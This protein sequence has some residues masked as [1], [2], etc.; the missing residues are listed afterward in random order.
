MT[1][2]LFLIALL[3][4]VFPHLGCAAALGAGP[5]SRPA[6]T[7]PHVARMTDAVPIDKLRTEHTDVDLRT[8]ITYSKDDV[9]YFGQAESYDNN[10]DVSATAP[11]V[12]SRIKGHW[13]A[14]SLSDDRLPD[15]EFLFIAAGPKKD[16]LWGV[17]D[18]QIGDPSSVL[19]LAHS[20]DSGQTWQLTT[21]NKPNAAGV[22][23]S[24]AMD[25]SGHGRVSV[26]LTKRES[27]NRPGYYH[28]RTTDAGRTWSAPER[29]PDSMTPADDIPDDEDPEPLKEGEKT[30]VSERSSTVAVP[31]S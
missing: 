23:D 11:L 22:F 14:L 24:F 26:Y 29:E 16:E 9:L 25:K 20:T 27:H 31:P 12:V 7:M 13:R 21:L 28:F 1:S 8:R 19:L 17:L 6:T 30:T 2:K 3:A 5:S 10:G 15:A 18:D 4:M